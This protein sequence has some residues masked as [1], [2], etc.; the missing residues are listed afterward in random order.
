M[1]EKTESESAVESQYELYLKGIPSPVMVIDKNF[2]IMYMNQCGRKLTGEKKSTVKGKKCYTVFK[3]GDCNTERCASARMFKSKKLETSQTCARLVSG[4]LPVQY[5]CS[6]LYDD[7]R[8]NVV[9]AIEVFTD[10]T[11]LKKAMDSMD[12]IIKSVTAVSEEVES[13]SNQVLQ[14][15]RTVGQMGLEAIQTCEKLQGNMKELQAASQNVATGAESLSELTQTTAKT[16]DYLVGMMKSVDKNTDEVNA[17][18][19]DSNNLAVKLEEDGKTTLASLN[20]IGDS[21]NKADK[22]INEVNASVQNVAGL[23]GDISEIAGQVNMLALNA[24]IEAAR[25]GQAGRGFAVVADAVKQLA[26]EPG[27]LLKQQSGPSMKS[28]SQ[29]TRLCRLQRQPRKQRMK[30]VASSVKQLKALSRLRAQ[31]VQSWQSRER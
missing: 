31:W 14:T 26:E 1:A 16:V 29:A 11:Q 7:Q 15:S 28:Q 3:T 21:L 12:A 17:L 18:V 20:N 13:L 6:P 25:A 10:I 4:D 27:H 8:V 24:A 22:T 5:T 30:V 2:G 9:G 23:A 19:K